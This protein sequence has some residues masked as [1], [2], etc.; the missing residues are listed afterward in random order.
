MGG[1]PCRGGEEMTWMELPF[2]LLQCTAL[3]LLKIEF[4]FI[5]FF[6]FT[7]FLVLIIKIAQQFSDVI[8]VACTQVIWE[9]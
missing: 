2:F 9:I 7:L 1:G 5:M 3:N 6:Y 4:V 8:P